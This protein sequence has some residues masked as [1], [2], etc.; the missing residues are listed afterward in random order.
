LTTPIGREGRRKEGCNAAAAAIFPLAREI[1]E[2]KVREPSL[3]APLAMP[4]KRLFGKMGEEG[5]WTT[6]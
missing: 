3:S 6:T 1:F 5:K 4:S 2:G